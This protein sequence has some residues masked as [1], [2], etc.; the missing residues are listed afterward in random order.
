MRNAPAAMSVVSINGAKK[1]NGS[2][3]PGFGNGVSVTQGDVLSSGAGHFG[4]GRRQVIAPVSGVVEAFIE[5]PGLLIIR[6][7]AHEDRIVARFAATVTAI[8]RT[9]I[10]VEITGHTIR[11]ALGAGPEVAGTLGIVDEAGSISDTLRTIV[12]VGDVS[13]PGILAFQQTIDSR[14]MRLVS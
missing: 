10:D 13:P 1:R 5:D 4:F 9:S 2:T 3:A 14:I 8:G 7:E 11:A 6:P 12:D